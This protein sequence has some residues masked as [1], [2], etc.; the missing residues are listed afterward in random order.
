MAERK[1]KSDVPK[2]SKAKAKGKSAKRPSAKKAAAAPTKTK[3]KKAGKGSKAKALT[4]EAIIAAARAQAFTHEAPP[5]AFDHFR[6]LAEAIPTDELPVFTGQA[7]LVRANVLTA[8]E[9]VA[10]HLTTAVLALREP[11]LREIF[12]LPALCMALDFAAGRVPVVSLSTGEIEAMLREGSP[13]RD[14]ML[15]FLEVAS[16]PLLDLLP[17]ERVAAVRSGTGKLDMAR[18]FVAL[19][20]LFAEFEASLAGK[21]PFPPQPIA[22]LA[23]LGSTLVQVVRPGRSTNNR[24]ARPAEAIL[25]DQLAWLVTERYD[26][27]GVI[28]TVAVGKRKADALLPALRSTAAPPRADGSSDDPSPEGTAAPEPA[29]A[30]A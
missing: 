3:G 16:H 27:L 13:W 19:P 2:K 25:R 11:P 8:L 28:A 24:P 18:D 20:G 22:R 26:Q 7:L 12:E 14:L 29:E 5:A 4:P 30:E 10:P 1:R 21:H 9:A 6:P 15:R 23:E 17:R